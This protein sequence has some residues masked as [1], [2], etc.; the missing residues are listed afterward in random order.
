MP[1]R[2]KRF[3]LE[4]GFHHFC[5]VSA[6]QISLISKVKVGCLLMEVCLTLD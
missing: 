5:L 1:L 3:V 6:S 2:D 4:I